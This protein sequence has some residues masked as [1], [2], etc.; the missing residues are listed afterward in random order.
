M[1]EYFSEMVESN[2]EKTLICDRDFVVGS[3]EVNVCRFVLVQEKRSC[4]VP[5][6]LALMFS[7]GLIHN[8]NSWQEHPGYQRP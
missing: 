6:D 7:F 5:T 8:E 4:S 3:L 2:Q 1:F